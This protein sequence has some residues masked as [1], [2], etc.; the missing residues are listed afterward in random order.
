MVLCVRDVAQ[1]SVLFALLRVCQE[2]L[3]VGI[4][5]ADSVAADLCRRSTVANELSTRPSSATTEEAVR[6][7]CQQG[8]DPIIARCRPLHW[9][10]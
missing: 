4:F 7:I 6:F 10:I 3:Q 8:H 1:F 2:C 9:A 5:C